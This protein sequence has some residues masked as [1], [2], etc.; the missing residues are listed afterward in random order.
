MYSGIGGAVNK[1]VSTAELLKKNLDLHQTNTIYFV[2]I[3]EVWAPKN[4]QVWQAS[5]QVYHSHTELRN[6]AIFYISL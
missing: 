5:I 1:A 2:T 6:F 4:N 3:T